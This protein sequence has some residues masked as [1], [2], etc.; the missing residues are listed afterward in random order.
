MSGKAS[1]II[2]QI[3]KML[4]QRLYDFMC[5]NTIKNPNA[6]TQALTQ[7][8]STQIRIMHAGIEYGTQAHM[9]H[10]L[11]IR[12]A[13]TYSTQA[14]LQARRLL[15]IY[16]YIYSS[17]RCPTSDNSSRQKQS[18]QRYRLNA[19]KKDH[20]NAEK[21]AQCMCA[22]ITF[23]MNT[24]ASGLLDRVRDRGDNSRE[25]LRLLGRWGIQR[26]S[27]RLSVLMR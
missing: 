15:R 4:Q 10:R 8:W 17:V 14:H 7:W 19:Y 20:N 27:S 24:S 2:V 22:Y 26:G 9:A 12:H 23:F 16:I 13:G 6:G 1:L 21:T 5:F 11:I 25:R 3:N 18:M